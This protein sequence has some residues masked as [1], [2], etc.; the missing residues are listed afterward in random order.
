MTDDRCAKWDSICESLDD[1]DEGYDVYEFLDGCETHEDKINALKALKEE[2][3]QRVSNCYRDIDERTIQGVRYLFSGAMSWGDDLQESAELFMNIEGISEIFDWLEQE[4]LEDLKRAKTLALAKAEQ[5]LE[6]NESIDL[7]ELTSITDEAAEVLSRYEGQLYLDGLTELSEA[8]VESLSKHKGMLSLNGLTELSDAAAEALS[9][10]KGNLSLAGLTELSEAAAESLSKLEHFLNLGVTSLTDAAVS[11]SNHEGD[12]FLNGLTELSDAAAESLSK[13]EGDLSLGG[14]TDLSD[15]AA[16]TLSKH[17]GKLSLGGLTKINSPA[18]AA[19]IREPEMTLRGLTHLT[20]DV[21][22][23][24]WNAEELKE[25]RAETGFPGLLAFWNLK[26]ISLETLR[27]FV[28]HP[29]HLSFCEVVEISDQAASVLGKYKAESL[30]LNS[31]TSLSDFAAE[32]LSEYEG[33]LMLADEGMITVSVAAA[34]SLSKRNG[35]NLF[36]F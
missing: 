13:H 22:S 29:G 15:A 20:P 31:L 36:T 25:H 27:E 28:D 23:E 21:A 34:E 35:I 6:D 4:A 32:A 10:H 19:V 14:L 8:A 5:F 3:G 12:L 24:L 18:L 30:C 16:E 33:E 9:K 11:L 1:L 17:E 2:Y 26:E 7:G